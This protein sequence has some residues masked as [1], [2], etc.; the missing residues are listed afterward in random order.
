MIEILHMLR[1]D[2]YLLFRRFGTLLSVRIMVS[3][4]T[5]LS[6]GF[7]FISYEDP[8]A[9]EWAITEMNGL[10]VISLPLPVFR[11][12]ES[13][14]NFIVNISRFSVVLVIS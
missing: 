12:I 14:T 6:R 11:I 13:I 2:L 3:S 9:A 5:G 10:R 4:S 8:I 1:R 7:G